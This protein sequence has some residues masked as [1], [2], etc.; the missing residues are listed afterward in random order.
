MENQHRQT[1]LGDHSPDL[2]QSIIGETEDQEGSNQEKIETE[3]TRDFINK[4]DEAQKRQIESLTDRVIQL[5]EEKKSELEEA[6]SNFFRV[7]KSWRDSTKRCNDLEEE[8]SRN[9][10]E[11]RKQFHK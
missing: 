3:Y 10:I 5:E 8:I 1:T 4:R 6:Y 2:S 9:E 7:E 11:R